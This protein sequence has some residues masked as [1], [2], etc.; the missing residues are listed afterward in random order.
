MAY[1]VA[2]ITLSDS[3]YKGER[4][5]V[6]G[7]V[8]AEIV[9]KEGYE[10]VRRELIPDEEEMLAA[11]LI[12]ICDGDEADLVL[13]TG[14]TGFSKRDRTP[15]ATK[16]VIERE[17]PGISEAMRYCSLQ[18]TPRGMLSRGVSG[19]RKDAL[20]VNLP[21]SP[22]AVRECLEYAIGALHHGLDILKGNAYN[23]AVNHK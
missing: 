23:C 7:G 10:V 2:I 21:G 22:K 9:E 13:T 16:R 5:D 1:R 6:S 8:I 14:G 18:V 19:I 4:E 15:E 20:I 17:T 3:G 11:L 12:Q